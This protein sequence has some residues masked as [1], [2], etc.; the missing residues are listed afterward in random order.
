MADQGPK[1]NTGSSQPRKLGRGLSALLGTPVEI[2]LQRPPNQIPSDG[3]AQSRATEAASAEAVIP[4]KVATGVSPSSISIRGAPEQ[5]FRQSAPDSAGRADPMVFVPTAPSGGVGVQGR[6]LQA[7]AVAATTST[8]EADIGRGIARG[9]DSNPTDVQATAAHPEDGVFES[10]SELRSIAVA[11]IVPNRRQPRKSFDDESI[12]AL[13]SSIRQAGL[14][15]PIL[16]RPMGARFELIAGERRWRAAKSLGMETIPALI[17]SV[18]DRVSAE[19]ALIENLQ[20]E[21]LN[22]MDRALALRQ[23]S[24]DFGMTH[25]EIADRIG[26]DR[27]SV[28]NLLRLSDLDPLTADLVRSGKI[29]Q[30]HAKALLAINVLK[31]RHELANQSANQF[32]SVRELERRIQRLLSSGKSASVEKGSSISPVTPRSANAADLE[33]KLSEHLGT[34]VTIQ[35]GRKKGSGRLILEFYSLDQFDGIMSRIGFNDSRI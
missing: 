34:R 12:R 3:S 11:S 25:Q 23:L 19:L 13:A 20:R 21:D 18:D 2:Q 1:P 16:V 7:G 17:S 33:R 28:S 26:L 8:P 32:W 24:D 6:P 4:A 5:S 35:L 14:M 22:P 15:Q 9:D 27:A 29:S 10:A 30:G 31:D